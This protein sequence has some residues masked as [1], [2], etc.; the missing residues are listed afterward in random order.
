MV[1]WLARCYDE[2]D[3][4]QAAAKFWKEAAMVGYSHIFSYHGNN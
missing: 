4:P 2:L 3:K 1:F